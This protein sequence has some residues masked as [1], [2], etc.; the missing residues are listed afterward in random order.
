M[1]EITSRHN[2]DILQ[3][4]FSL[5]KYNL[6]ATVTESQIVLEN[7]SIP[8]EV[9]E[10]I[11]SLVKTPI[12]KNFRTDSSE[13]NLMQLSEKIPT[14]EL[15]IKKST[16][17]TIASTNVSFDLKFRNP[18]PGTVFLA[19]F[20][21]PYGHEIGFE[22]PVI[23]LWT[24]NSKSLIIPCTTN[25]NKLDGSF[26][27][28][29]ARQNF[30]QVSLYYE[31]NFIPKTSLA[32]INQLR[33]IDQT[34]LRHELGTL[35]NNVFN[36]IKTNIETYFSFNIS[37][38]S[39]FKQDSL[40]STNE[41]EKSEIVESP[42][43][44]YNEKIDHILNSF[45]FDLK[46]KGTE[47]L[48]DAIVSSLDFDT[49]NLETLCQVISSKTGVSKTEIERLIVARYKENFNKKFKSIDFIRLVRTIL[50]EGVYES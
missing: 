37:D 39:S 17:D 29:L 25:L 2:F 5:A 31:K 30:K 6:Q 28:S 35:N 15:K 9:L 41:V 49:F 21:E 18:N 44:D 36:D 42:N 13:T 32:L 40:G 11:L 19:D 22:R 23:V 43:D 14:N 12:I 47:Y 26:D 48:K 4:V 27:I 46:V 33:V 24:F 7:E 38:L 50:K 45:G 34:R 8:N 20:G 3:L 16:N 1:L 10:S